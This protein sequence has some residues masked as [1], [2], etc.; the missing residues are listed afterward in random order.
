MITDANIAMAGSANFDIR[1]LFLNCELMSAFYSEHDIR[2]L[3]Q[4]FVSLQ[5]NCKRYQTQN[6]TTTELIEGLAL[7]AVRMFRKNLP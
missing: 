2:R 6:L 5:K 7:L 1:S 4:W 3:N